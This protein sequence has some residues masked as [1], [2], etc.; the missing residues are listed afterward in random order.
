MAK[1]KEMATLKIDF[2]RTL[3]QENGA[4][5][6]TAEELNGVPDSIIAG[7][8]K[9]TN[10]HGIEVYAMSFKGVDYGPVVE[11]AQS[12]S[13]RRRAAVGFSNRAQ[14]NAPI[15]DRVLALRRE[16]AEILGYDTWAAYV[17]EVSFSLYVQPP[18]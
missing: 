7:F 10:E 13:T 9:R 18:F 12:P 2:M 6:F 16:C 1:Q 15:F 4:L 5:D 17:L 3:N 8:H 11:Y 14:G